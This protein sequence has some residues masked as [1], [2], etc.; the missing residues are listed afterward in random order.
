MKSNLKPIFINLG[1]VAAAITLILLLLPHDDR[2]SY[3]YELNQPWRYQLLTADFDMPILRD[4]AS[5]RLMRDSIDRAF[6]PLVRRD[7]SVSQ[8]NI[9]GFRKAISAKLPAPRATLL[10]DLLT[11]AYSFGIVDP[12]VY[13]LIHGGAHGHLRVADVE[14]GANAVQTIDAHEMLSPPKAFQYIDSV[15]HSGLHGEQASETLDNEVAHMLGAVL[16]PNI[17]IDSVADRKFRGQEYLTVNGA[18]GVIKKGQ[19]IVDRGEIVTPQIFTNLNTY[20][21]IAERNHHEDNRTSY[22]L[23]GQA[24]YLLLCFIALFVYLRIFRSRFLSSTKNMVFL[25]SFISA[26]AIFAILMFEYVGNGIYFVPFAAIPLVIL[27]FFDSRTAIFSLLVSVMISALVAVFPFQF[28]FMELTAGLSAAFSIKTLERRSQLLLTALYTFCAYVLSY[29]ISSL[30]AD[31][32]L[33]SFDWHI[34]GAFAINAVVLSFAYFLILIIEKIYGFTSTVTLVELSD[35]N[36]PLL[37]RLAEEAPGTFQHSMQ[38]STLAAEAARAIGANTQL[39]RTGALYHDIGKLDGPIFFTENQHGVNPHTG[40]NPETS[41]HKIISHVAS[42]LSIA[43]SEKLPEVIRRFISEHHGRSVARFFYNTAVNENP[44]GTVDRAK[45]TYPGPNP[46]S[47]E[48]AILMMADAVEAASRS[49]P[50]YTPDAI[51]ALVDKIIDGQEKE[52]LFDES[53]ISFRDILT[54]KN[55]FKKRLSTIYHSRVAY[56]ELRNSVLTQTPR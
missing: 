52:G 17:V 9:A 40:L 30:V 33:A 37:R 35:I 38:V 27:V 45:F 14:N 6:V 28:I 21:E 31:G 46:Q 5:A 34:I 18:L 49:L 53:P 15:Y 7:A 2:Q 13:D 56:P 44:E 26:F 19:R 36:N 32:T 51:G 12:K 4:S 3:N 55:T 11:R 50:E 43:Q 29:V 47:R 22:F 54:I 41:A 39:V 24:L 48:T 42:G 8:T 10:A 20:M 23:V 1:L 16:I 25:I